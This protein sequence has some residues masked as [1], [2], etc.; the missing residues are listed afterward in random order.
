[1]KT[2][3]PKQLEIQNRDRSILEAARHILVD[4]G[5][6]GL[7][8]DRIAE[9]VNY[10]KGTIYNHFSCKEEVIIALAIENLQLRTTLFRKAAEYPGQTRHRMDAVGVAAE[11]FVRHDPTYF[12]FE[13]L[14]RLGSVMEKVSEK[15]QSIINSCELQCMST[16][17]G[18]VRAG[19]AARELKLPEGMTPEDVVF[20]LWA[21]TS[22]G[23]SIVFSSESLGQLGLSEPFQLV[24]RHSSRLMDG[25]DWH[26]LSTTYDVDEMASRIRK[27]LFSEYNS[28]VSVSKN[29]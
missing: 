23:Y 13:Q 21:M 28:Q 2:L 22:G 6:H 17:G 1:M 24:R 16:V 14:L 15:R 12:Q 20:G 9:Q 27:E 8:M 19:M 3:T 29:R 5:Y 25:F 18:I 4:G 26:P 10:S 11:I 7:N